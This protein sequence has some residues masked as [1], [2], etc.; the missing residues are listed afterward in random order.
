[1]PLEQI[2]EYGRSFIRNLGNCACARD[3]IWDSTYENDTF[4]HKNDKKYMMELTN[5]LLE[6]ERSVLKV[7]LEC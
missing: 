4:T 5:L 7:C 3:C 1:M 6:V 2:D